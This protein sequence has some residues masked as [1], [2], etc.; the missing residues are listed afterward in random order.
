MIKN[1]VIGRKTSFNT[2][3]GK[4]SGSI[5]LSCNYLFTYVGGKGDNQIC[6]SVMSLAY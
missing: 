5:S 4:L 1:A 2:V 3:S 6:H